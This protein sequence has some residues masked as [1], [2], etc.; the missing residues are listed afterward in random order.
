RDSAKDHPTIMEVLTAFI[1]EHSRESW[2]VDGE[3]AQQEGKKTRPDVQAAAT[4]AGRRDAKREILPIDLNGAN[5]TD[6][7]LT[8]ANFTDANL[9]DAV[10]T[11]AKL[12]D[13][14]LAGANLIHAELTDARLSR[15][16][17][18]GANLN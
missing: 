4:V 12:T 1:R 11:G 8:S 9:A 3:G 10:L 5:L 18:G 15:A 16:D 17:L 14:V 13:A 6:A 7:D 2:P